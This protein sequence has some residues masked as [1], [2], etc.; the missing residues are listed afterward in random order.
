[1]TDEVWAG[2]RLEADPGGL[3]GYPAQRAVPDPLRLGC[4]TRLRSGTV[5]YQGGRIG[6]RVR[7]N[8]NWYIAQYTDI[9]DDAFLAPGVTIANDLYPG[10]RA[11]AEVMSAPLS[12]K[13]HS[14][15]ST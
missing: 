15:V 6:N 1:M 13:A 4:D 5:P 7:I 11:S 12:E 3:L 10:Q 2:P 8:A 9:R 14:W